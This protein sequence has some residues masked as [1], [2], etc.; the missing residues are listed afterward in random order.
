MY[1]GA[2]NCV[3]G[4]V[5]WQWFLAADKAFMG[6]HVLPKRSP[7]FQL[8]LFV[9]RHLPTPSCGLLNCSRPGRRLTDDVELGSN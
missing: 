2:T 8:E 1:S 9:R 6:L 7:E 5:L 3:I 4:S